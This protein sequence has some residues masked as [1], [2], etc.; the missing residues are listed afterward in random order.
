MPYLL[1]GGVGFLVYRGLRQKAL[2][3]RQAA[4]PSLP[5]EGDRKCSDR[6]FARDDDS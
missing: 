4:A 5:G 2:A 3:E 1:L 6:F